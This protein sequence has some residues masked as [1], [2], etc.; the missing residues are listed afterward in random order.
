[1]SLYFSFKVAAGVNVLEFKPFFFVL[2]VVAEPRGLANAG[3]PPIHQT[4]LI[5]SLVFK[6]IWFNLFLLG[7]DI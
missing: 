1:M 2:A 4:F 7:L 5:H 3:N 6:Q